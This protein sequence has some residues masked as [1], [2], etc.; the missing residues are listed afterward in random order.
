MIF[1]LLGPIATATASHLELGLR[2]CTTFYIFGISPSE[3]GAGRGRWPPL[4]K[5]SGWSEH[6][7]GQP[8]GC[9]SGQAGCQGEW[10]TEC[11]TPLTRSPCPILHPYP[12]AT[13]TEPPTLFTQLPSLFYFSKTDFVFLEKFSIHLSKPASCWPINP[14]NIVTVIVLDSL[15][16]L[17][18][19][20]M[21]T[22]I[23]PHL[24]AWFVSLCI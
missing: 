23:V 7:V 11:R 18:R 20:G 16:N 1:L 9:W 12:H 2:H 19:A 4:V 3:A 17:E 5:D 24:G 22:S 6:F 10:G 14:F 15:L 8:A 13:Y 21:F